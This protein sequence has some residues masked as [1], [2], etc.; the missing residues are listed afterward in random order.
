MSFRKEVLS[1]VSFSRSVTPQ[2]LCQFTVTIIP[3]KM[4]Q[5]ICYFPLLANAVEAHS[6]PLAGN[7]FESLQGWTWETCLML[8]CSTLGW[9]TTSC[10]LPA[11]WVT[12]TWK[13]SFYPSILKTLHLEER[14]CSLW[15]IKV[16]LQR[17]AM[18]LSQVRDSAGVSS[19]TDSQLSPSI[20]YFE[21]FLYKVSET[22]LTKAIQNPNPCDLGHTM[23]LSATDIISYY[24][25]IRQRHS[26]L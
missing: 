13:G 10:W 3:L 16:K 4:V 6:E 18:C 14:A 9:K 2:Q 20:S 24:G 17:C 11:L 15:R 26:L 25:Q 7:V 5:M 8:L 21:P 1:S 23:C 12:H 22:E 19:G